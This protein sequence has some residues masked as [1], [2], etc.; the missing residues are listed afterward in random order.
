MGI[1]GHSHPHGKYL[2]HLGIEKVRAPMMFAR[3]AHSYKPCEVEEIHNHSFWKLLSDKNQ[4]LAGSCRKRLHWRLDER[5]GPNADFR[6]V[7]SLAH[8]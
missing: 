6:I 7:Q 5:E 2:Q 8:V 4:G 1:D 3:T